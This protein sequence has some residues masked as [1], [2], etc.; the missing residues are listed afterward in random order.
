[1]SV[2]MARF[3][4]ASFFLSLAAAWAGG[5][6]GAGGQALETAPPPAV[7]E[8][9]ADWVEVVPGGL[10]VILGAPHGGDLRPEEL[11]DRASGVLLRDIHT[12]EITRLAAAEMERLYGAAPYLVICRVHRVKVDCNRSIGEAAQGDPLAEA[13]WHAY[14]GAIARAREEVESAWGAGLFLDIHGHSHPAARIEL[15]YRLR[16]QEL[17]L[18]DEALDTLPEILERVSARELAGRSPET[19]SALLRGPRSLGGLLEA[20]G[21]PCVPSPSVPTPG[22]EPFFSGG[23]SVETHGSRVGGTV[24]AIQ[25]ELPRRVVRET[26]G[27]RQAFAK[28]LAGALGPYFS[29]HFQA[30]LRQPARAG[31]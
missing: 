2:S 8:I 9:P 5:V 7:P 4:V 16:R 28:A 13:L 20:R 10:P 23:Y 22:A 26:A 12:E 31:E 14:H 30:E 21:F 25:I 24:S 17:D 27:T 11:P 6:A 19:L 3:K 18:A 15:G 29:A 1:M